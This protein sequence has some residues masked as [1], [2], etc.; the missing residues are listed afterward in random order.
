M[1][2][3][4]IDLALRSKEPIERLN[5]LREY[6][7]AAALRSLHEARAF[8]RLSFVG[9]TALRFLFDLPRYSEDLDFS[10][11]SGEG[12]EPLSWFAKLKRDLQ[13]QGFE[14]EVSLNDRKTVHIVW[15]RI[16]G[17]LKEADIVGRMEQ[18]LSIKLE[19]DTRPPAGAAMESHLVNRHFVFALRH[20]DLPSLMAGK[21]HALLAR[22]YAKGRDWYDLVWYRSRRPPVEPNG[23]LLEAALRQ[24]ETKV[25]GNWR[26]HLAR[27][28]C[29]LD[30]ASLRADIEPFLERR[31]D[32]AFI[33]REAIAGLL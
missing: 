14:A 16:A 7:Q 27:R 21:V 28:L 5:I 1:R 13:R 20:H 9:G 10:L 23:T 17:I 26:A 2:S 33:T 30:F 3:E 8:E 25:E 29:E 12:Y 4:A 15:I 32:A 22:P 18:K 11:E 6:V 19:I 31:E 24:T